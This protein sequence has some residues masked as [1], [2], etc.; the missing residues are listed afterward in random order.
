MHIMMSNQ[1][2]IEI[3]GLQI[4]LNQKLLKEDFLQEDQEITKQEL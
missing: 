3:N 1:L 2:V 4:R